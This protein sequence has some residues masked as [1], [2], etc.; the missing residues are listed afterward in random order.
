[1]NVS[2]RPPPLS[3]LTFQSKANNQFAPCYGCCIKWRNFRIRGHGGTLYF[4]L[5]LLPVT[6]S[7]YNCYQLLRLLPVATSFYNCYQL[8]QL[9]PVATSRYQLV[10]L[11]P[12]GTI[13]TSYHNFYQLLPVASRWIQ[14]VA[15][16]FPSVTAGCHYMQITVLFLSIYCYSKGV[17]L[18]EPPLITN[19]R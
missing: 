18:L 1:M 5:Q 8:L 7:C 15:V 10:Q 14:A 13:D 17:P 12:V 9:L 6:A 4:V 16:A 11:L 3:L 19:N 2:L